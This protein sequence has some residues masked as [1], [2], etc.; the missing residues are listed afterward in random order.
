[1]IILL[2]F[3]YSLSLSLFCLNVNSTHRARYVIVFENEDKILK[4]CEKRV[5][6]LDIFVK[7]LYNNIMHYV[8][9]Y[10]LFGTVF[11]TVSKKWL[12]YR[13]YLLIC[14]FTI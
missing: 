5:F 1:M 8:F 6:G 9:I 7:L 12:E 4:I 10:S 14:I 11:W 3:F 13:I 2:V